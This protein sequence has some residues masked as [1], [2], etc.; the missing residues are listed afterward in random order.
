[1]PPRKKPV[2]RKKAAP[3]SV[4]LS[5]AETRQ[6]TSREIDALAVIGIWGVFGCYLAVRG[7]SWE[8]SRR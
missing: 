6:V 7:F 2:R 3:A 4:G 1:M 5:P 8:Q